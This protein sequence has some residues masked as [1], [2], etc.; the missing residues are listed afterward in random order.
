MEYWSNGKRVG[1]LT[2]GASLHSS[3][4]VCL[5][6]LS[7]EISTVLTNLPQSS[8]SMS[9]VRRLQSS[10]SRY[11]GVSEIRWI[12]WTSFGHQPKAETTRSPG[13]FVGAYGI[14]P[15]VDAGFRQ[16]DNEQAK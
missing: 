12:T 3:S 1:Q 8:R 16:H 5:T 6:N 14:R 4:A 7:S 13:I 2:L 10:S 15:G 11:C 9:V